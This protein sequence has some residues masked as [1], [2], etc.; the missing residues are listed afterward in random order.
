MGKAKLVEAILVARRFRHEQRYRADIEKLVSEFVALGAR[1]TDL[2]I[3]QLQ[4]T[5]I[6]LLAKV[7]DKKIHVAR[8]EA[9]GLNRDASEAVAAWLNEIRELQVGIAALVGELSGRLSLAL[10]DGEAINRAA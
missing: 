10:D 9:E 2:G 3:A 1:E 8:I 7:S 5:T 6:A 4:A